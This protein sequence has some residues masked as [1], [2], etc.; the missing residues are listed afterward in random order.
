MGEA[1]AF[2]RSN[3]PKLFPTS[4]GYGLIEDAT[5]G[6]DAPDIEIFSTPTAWVDHGFGEVP[7]GQL[8]S[9]TQYLL[10]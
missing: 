1:V 5:S 7:P 10:R 6:S 2:I 8:F 3:D 4:E 9:I